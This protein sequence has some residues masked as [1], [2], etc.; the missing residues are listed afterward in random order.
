MTWSNVKPLTENAT[1]KD[2]IRYLENYTRRQNI[3]IVG[4]KEN[5]GGPRP[6]EFIANLLFELFGQDTFSEMLK[7]YRAH[8]SLAPKPGESDR[9]TAI[10]SKA[11][12]FKVKGTNSAPCEREGHAYLQQIKNSHFPGLQ[13]RG[14]Q[15][16][17]CV[18]GMQTEAPCRPRQVW[19]VLSSHTTLQPWQDVVEVHRSS[20]GTRVHQQ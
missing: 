12:S 3:R 2:K 6:T 20:G 14:Q 10:H 5:T 13:L 4:I 11:A 17:C 15:I 18:F 19:Y 7:V 1:L 9:T 16:M 8:R